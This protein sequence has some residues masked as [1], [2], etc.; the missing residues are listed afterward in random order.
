MNCINPI[1]EDTNL[2]NKK[3]STHK[4]TWGNLTGNYG[5][6]KYFTRKMAEAATLLNSIQDV[7]GLNVF[8]NTG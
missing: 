7:I 8:R 4:F 5:C 2:R 6:V 1:K 3:N